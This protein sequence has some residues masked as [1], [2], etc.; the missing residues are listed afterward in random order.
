MVYLLLFA[1]I[2]LLR[3][4]PILTSLSGTDTRKGLTT[5][6]TRRVASICYLCA[7]TVYIVLRGS[8]TGLITLVSSLREIPYRCFAASSLIPWGNTNAS[9]VTSKELFGAVAGETSPTST[10]SLIT[11]LISLQFRLFAIWLSFS[12]PSLHKNLPFYSP[13]F[14]FVVFSSD[15]FFSAILLRSHDDSIDHQVV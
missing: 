9:Q 5:P 14:S 13:S 6:L 12:S 10:R 15:L 11:N 1:S 7:G 2:N 8:P 4:Y 3:S